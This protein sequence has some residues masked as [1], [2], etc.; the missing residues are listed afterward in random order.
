MTATIIQ[1][2][3]VYGKNLFRFIRKINGGGRVIGYDGSGSFTGNGYGF[4][5]VI[6]YYF[7]A[8]GIYIMF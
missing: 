6:Y 3:Q 8:E 5:T 7:F 1:T 4:I 2:V